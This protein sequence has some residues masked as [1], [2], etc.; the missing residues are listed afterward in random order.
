MRIIQTTKILMMFSVAAVGLATVGCD[1][2]TTCADGGVCPSGAGGTGHGGS[3]AGGAGAAGGASGTTLYGVTPGT[4]C[5][6]ITAATPTADGCGIFVGVNYVGMRIPV[7]YV[8]A[9]GQITVGTMGALGTGIIDQN[10]GTL[11]RENNPADPTM[12]TCTWHQTDTTALTVTAENMFTANVTE[13]ES[14][15]AAVCNPPPLSDP[16]TS[17]FTL[18]LAIHAPALMPDAVTGL[19]P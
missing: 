13:T 7:T 12:P 2:T 19:C 5:F 14:A 18:K 17:T 9:T 4:Y 3:G 1:S 11:L 10:V 6:D 8:A 16:C 15:F